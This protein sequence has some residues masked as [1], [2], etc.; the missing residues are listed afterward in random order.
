[1][2]ELVR[3]LNERLAEKDAEIERL[4]A[5]LAVKDNHD[6]FDCAAEMARKDIEIAELR[7]AWILVAER[8]ALRHHE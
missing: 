6:H 2:S 8:E 3:Q 1:M 4:R 5:A 7:E